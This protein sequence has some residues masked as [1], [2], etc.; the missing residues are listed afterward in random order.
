MVVLQVFAE[1]GDD[2]VVHDEVRGDGP[3]PG[4]L[5]RDAGVARRHVFHGVVLEFSPAVQHPSEL[6]RVEALDR[7]GQ[8]PV[9]LD[10]AAAVDW[11]AR[12]RPLQIAGVVRPGGVLVV[13]PVAQILVEGRVPGPLNEASAG[14]AAAAELPV[15]VLRDLALVDLTRDATVLAGELIR[16]G[17]M[18]EKGKN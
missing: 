18:P 10:A 3:A 5:L 8:T 7:S 1:V 12:V 16:G 13:G 2:G 17:A 9:G 4:R 14:E 11:T 15:A 6:R